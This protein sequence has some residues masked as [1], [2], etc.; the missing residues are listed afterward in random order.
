LR[1]E[2]GYELE[3][4]CFCY[5][6]AGS[7]SACFCVL[8]VIVVQVPAEMVQVLAAGALLLMEV[9]GVGHLSAQDPAIPPQGIEAWAG[10]QLLEDRA[11]KIP[12]LPT[13]MIAISAQL[14]FLYL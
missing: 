5:D 12:L 7:V 11:T 4:V 13:G 3:L 8:W 10:H 6:M 9:G 1:R 2:N 14:D